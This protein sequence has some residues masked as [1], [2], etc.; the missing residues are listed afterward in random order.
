MPTFLYMYIFATIKNEYNTFENFIIQKC[1]KNLHW[2]FAIS[3]LLVA[4]HFLK[5]YYVLCIFLSYPP[6]PTNTNIIY[7]WISMVYCLKSQL[8]RKYSKSSVYTTLE[9]TEK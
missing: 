9:Q 4:L 6:L 7:T 8:F 2:L 5:E 1:Y 3:C